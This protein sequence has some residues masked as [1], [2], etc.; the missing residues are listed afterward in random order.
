MHSGVLREITG[1]EYTEQSASQWHETA[2]GLGGEHVA[3][4]DSFSI[5]GP[6]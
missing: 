6:C 1:T 5:L 4:Y 2:Q 3:A